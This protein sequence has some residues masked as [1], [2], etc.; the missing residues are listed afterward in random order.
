MSEMFTQ[1]SRTG[2]TVDY[3]HDAFGGFNPQ[4]DTDAAVKLS[5]DALVAD[6]RILELSEFVARNSE[7]DGIE[8]EPGW[9]IE[10]RKFSDHLD[11]DNWPNGANFRAYVDPK[12]Y[13]LRYPEFFCDKDTF[14]GYVRSILAVYVDRNPG[15]GDLVRKI[16]RELG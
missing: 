15:Q 14:Y 16:L 13:P 9:I 5:L 3:F 2:K 7:F 4:N 8:G 11:S 6:H 12:E 1:S 10:R